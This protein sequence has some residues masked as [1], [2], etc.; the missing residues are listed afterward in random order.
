MTLSQTRAMRAAISG[1]RDAQYRVAVECLDRG[2][3]RR[4]RYFSKDPA[5]TD[6][7]L[8]M[9]FYQ[10]VMNNVVKA[11][12]NVGDPY[13]FLIQCGLWA[14][15]DKIRQADA[16]PTMVRL[17]ADSWEEHYRP[18]APSDD[19]TEAEAVAL[20]YRET[21][22]KRVQQLLDHEAADENDVKALSTQERAW[23]EATLEGTIDPTEKGANMQFADL[24]GVCPQRASQIVNGVRRK[25]HQLIAA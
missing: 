2:R 12:L 23:I 24:I 3:A 10:G 1:D 13:G 16:Q 8:D 19:D 11:K 5:V 18:E 25:A 22:R 14:V 17:D 20:V 21:V 6:D 4:A 9:A 15:L 7:D